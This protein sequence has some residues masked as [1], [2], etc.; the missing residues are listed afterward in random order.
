MWQKAFLIF[1]T[2]KTQVFKMYSKCLKGANRLTLSC[3][4]NKTF[5][6][7][8][9]DFWP[10]NGS[11]APTWPLG[12]KCRLNLNV[13]IASK[14]VWKQMEHFLLVVRHHSCVCPKAHWSRR[15][16]LF[17]NPASESHISNI[18]GQ[19]V[20]DVPIWSSSSPWEKPSE[21]TR[22]ANVYCINMDS[23]PLLVSLPLKPRGPL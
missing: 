14:K 13:R 17:Y 9:W 11:T 15:V 18:Y 3:S 5:S 16:E 10:L 4:G 6:I 20:T 22:M 7:R 21:Q 2:L 23:S 1:Q 12:I 19:F 8:L